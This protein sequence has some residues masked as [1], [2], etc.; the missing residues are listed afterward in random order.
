MVRGSAAYCSGVACWSQGL[1]FKG[2]RYTFL[3]L[4]C[5][6]CLGKSLLMSM[7]RRPRLAPGRVLCVYFAPNGNTTAAVGTGRFFLVHDSVNLMS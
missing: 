7:M 6:T 5:R 4:S 3:L 1:S 2:T